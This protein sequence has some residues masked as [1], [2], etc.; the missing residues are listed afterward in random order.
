M[1]RFSR[2]CCR[3]IDRILVKLLGCGWKI[4]REIGDRPGFSRGRSLAYKD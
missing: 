1:E 2:S 3:G 4:G